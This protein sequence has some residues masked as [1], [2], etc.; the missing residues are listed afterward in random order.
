MENST[1]EA[2]VAAALD[3]DRLQAMVEEQLEKATEKW[4]KDALAGYNNP[5]KKAFEERLAEVMVSAVERFRLDNARLEVVL[6]NVINESAVG[7]RA[8]LLENFGKLALSESRDAIPASELLDE[9]A[10]YAASAYDCDGREV[11]HDSGNPSYEYLECHIELEVRDPGYRSIRKDATLLLY[12]EDC[13]EEQQERICR[14]IRLWRWDD[15]PKDPNRWLVSYPP[16]PTFRGLAKADGFDI[17][18]AHLELAGTEILWDCGPCGT[19]VSVE[20]D[21]QPDCTWG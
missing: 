3:P 5:I 17:Y 15:Y 2:A 7:E 1:L 11:V 19:S 4:V 16:Q 10:K 13:D 20:P 21:E 8:R 9:Y 12:V 18:L 6:S 14:A